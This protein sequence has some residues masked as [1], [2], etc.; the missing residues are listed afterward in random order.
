MAWQEIGTS[1]SQE[2]ND[3]CPSA[4]ASLRDQ[5]DQLEKMMPQWAIISQQ[6]DA[7]QPFSTIIIYEDMP[8]R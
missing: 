7:P 2:I 5:I 3:S 1:W 6:K 4:N 8:G